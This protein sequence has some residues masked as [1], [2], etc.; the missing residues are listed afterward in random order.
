VP[1]SFS[2]EPVFVDLLRSPRIDSQPGEID[3]SESIPGLHK[4][5]Q[6]RALVTEPVLCLVIEEFKQPAIQTKI[7]S[8]ALRRIFSFYKSVPVNRKKRFNASRLPKNEEIGGSFVFD[9]SELQTLFKNSRSKLKNQKPIAV[10]VL[11]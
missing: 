4:H 8:A 2:P 9:G 7:H 6:I 1:H 3:S 5:L 11:S 10:D